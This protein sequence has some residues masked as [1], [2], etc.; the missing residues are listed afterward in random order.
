MTLFSKSDH[1][2]NESGSMKIGGL[3]KLTLLD[4]PGHVACTVFT[5]GCNWR[6]PFCHNALLLSGQEEI[7]E[8][9]IFTYLKKRRGILDG[10]AITGGEPLLHPDLEELSLRIRDLGLAVKLDT[11]GSFP[12]RLEA[13]IKKGML[14]YVA[15]DI[16]NAPGQYETTIGC[17]KA[18]LENVQKSIDLLMNGTLP[19]EFRTTVVRELHSEIGLAEIGRWLKGAPKYFIQPYRDSDGVLVRGFHA[20]E[21]E[22]LIRML[23]AVRLGIPTAE[24]RGEDV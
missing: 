19:F 11:N 3:Q 14:D 1:R 17:E 10:V 13:L 12:D 4:F 6:C 21:R 2:R 9:G 23:Q 16:K 20:P 8:E 5:S 24:I 15:M 7:D 18:P 22:E